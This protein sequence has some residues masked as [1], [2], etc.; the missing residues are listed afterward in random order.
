MT[1]GIVWRSAIKADRGS[2]MNFTCTEPGPKNPLKGWKAEHP[3]P[4]EYRVQSAIRDLRPPY[5][6][7]KFL[8]VGLDAKGVAAA[9]HW[10]EVSG[11]EQVNVELVAIARRHRR[12][13]DRSVA[14]ELGEQLTAALID[15]VLSV[16]G[17]TSALVTAVVHPENAPSRRFCE[18]GGLECTGELDDGHLVYS[19]EQH[20]L[21]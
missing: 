18:E 16:P 13:P 14:K 5:A 2:L 19:L 21:F 9:V 8:L 17:L 11:P 10:R 20:L 4:W 6:P 7:P 3:K 1:G 12:T 15:R